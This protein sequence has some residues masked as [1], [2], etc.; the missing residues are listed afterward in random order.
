VG[1]SV[2]DADGVVK[3]KP[4]QKRIHSQLVYSVAALSIVL[5]LIGA[6]AAGCGGSTGSKSNNP[7]GSGTTSSGSGTTSSGS[8]T[9]SGTTTSKSGWG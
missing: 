4:M 1:K 7:A 9:T 3:V 8:G 6:L 5:A 2:L